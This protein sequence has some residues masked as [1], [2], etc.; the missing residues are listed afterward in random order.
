MQ[1]TRNKIIKQINVVYCQR[2]FPEILRKERK[3]TAV[4]LTNTTT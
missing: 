2:R 3:H 1:F 4:C